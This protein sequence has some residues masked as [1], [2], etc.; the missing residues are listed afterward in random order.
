MK[1]NYYFLFIL[2][3]SLMFARNSDRSDADFAMEMQQQDLPQSVAASYY[4]VP[5]TGFNHD[6][7]ANGNGQANTTT[8]TTIDFSNEY[9]SADFV[10]TTV[11]N[12]AS[13]AVFGGG[14]P[15]N[16]Q[17][18][19]A[20]TA[21]VTYQLAD[22]SA[23]NALLIRPLTTNTGTLTFGTQ[24]TATSLYILWV[25]TEAQA[26]TVGVTV[27][28][29]DGTSQAATNQIAYDWVGGTTGIALGNLSRVGS[30][31]TQWAQLNEFSQSGACKL[32]E[33]KIDILAANQGKA[34]TG[35]SFSYSPGGNFQ[36]L[37]V[38]AI[39]VFGESLAV[40]S[41]VKNLVSI[42][43][44]PSADVFKVQSETG[45]KSITALNTLGQQVRQANGDEISL[46][47]A[48]SGVYFLKIQLEND[49][50]ETRRVIKK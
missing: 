37:V 35:V 21:G 41:N 44:N 17:I 14:L 38:F 42:Y 5:L 46:A 33:K 9:F 16:G 15:A 43:P 2:I 25:A 20:V 10:P 18:T 4:S 48:N 12:S 22:Y 32:F 26:S 6:V 24:Y 13:A 40:N 39:N 23:S 31:S 45:V 49:L 29:A 19:S 3:S 47:D 1:N 7:I 30:G 27:N 50:T 11:Y 34:I 28:F 8:T 36:S